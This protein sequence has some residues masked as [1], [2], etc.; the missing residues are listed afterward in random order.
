MSGVQEERGGKMA[1]TVS[2]TW[3]EHRQLKRATRNSLE[4]DEEQFWKELIDKYLHPMRLDKKE[5]Q[6]IKSGLEDLRNKVAFVFFMM[7]GLFIM[8]VFLLQMKKDCL[9]VEWP[10]GPK[11]NRSFIPCDSMFTDETWEVTGLQLEPIGLVFLIFFM[12]ILMIQFSAMLFHRLGTL[13]HIIA[14]TELF[15]F[16]SKRTKPSEEELVVANAVEIARELQAI[17]GIDTNDEDPYEEENHISRRRV[18]QHLE[19]SRRADG[20]HKTETLDAAFRKR[21]FA[22]RADDAGA[23]SGDSTPVLGGKPLTARRSTRQ[24]ITKRRN[25][26]FGT[27]DAED[28]R[29]YESETRL[30]ED[31]ERQHRAPAQRRL[32]QIFQPQ[33]M[34][35]QLATTDDESLRIPHPASHQ[36]LPVRRGL[37]GGG[38]QPGWMGETGRPSRQQARD[39]FL[40]EAASQSSNSPPD[41]R[42]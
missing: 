26:I 20:R 17:K 25:S 18:V 29:Q 30:D 21:F 41:S 35:Q 19:S 6:R 40:L 4:P 12:S 7:N 3:L 27:L 9:H 33:H 22:L 32:E 5:Q 11:V 42:L 14:S 24:A 16:R 10:L 36:R 2:E 37:G 15:C 38:G 1:Q 31:T 8:I 28:K 13:A 39:Q 23:V 34:Q